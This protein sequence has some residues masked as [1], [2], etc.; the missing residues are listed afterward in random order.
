MCR[1]TAFGPYDQLILTFETEGFGS[2]H[3]LPEQA[4]VEVLPKG[5]EEGE[6]QVDCLGV[7]ALPDDGDL[8]LSVRERS[9]AATRVKVAVA[10]R[11]RG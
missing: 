9:Y 3:E 5:P 1:L 11:G 7:N 4:T 6:I 8:Y 10:V 2:V